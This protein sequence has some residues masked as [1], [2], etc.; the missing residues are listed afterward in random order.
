MILPSSFRANHVEPMLHGA[1]KSL[2]IFLLKLA[3]VK[4]LRSGG[5][6]QDSQGVVLLVD[7]F[8]TD[9]DEERAQALLL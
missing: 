4:L 8:M 5:S 2:L 9:F 6:E 3:H 7:D 1:N